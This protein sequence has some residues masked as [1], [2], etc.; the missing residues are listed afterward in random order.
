MIGVEPEACP[1]LTRAMDAGCPAD[2]ES[3]GIAA[4]SLAPLRVGN[5]MFP[6]AQRYISR[7]LLVPDSAIRSAQQTLW[8]TLRVV[9]EPGGAAAFAALLSHQYR[10]ARGSEWVSCSAA[11]IRLRSI[12]TALNVN[13]RRRTL[14]SLI[15]ESMDGFTRVFPNSGKHDFRIAC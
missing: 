14:P 10:P 8:Q 3:G 15:E 12:L 9:A 11:P 4:D 7:V 6:I 5:L 13:L 2:A 1:T